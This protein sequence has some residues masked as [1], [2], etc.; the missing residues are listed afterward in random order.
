[1]GRAAPA[2]ERASSQRASIE[3]RTAEAGRADAERRLVAKQREE[4]DSLR[5]RRGAEKAALALQA[6]MAKLTKTNSDKSQHKISNAETLRL[7]TIDVQLE[8]ARHHTDDIPRLVMKAIRRVAKERSVPLL[9]VLETLV[10]QPEWKFIR[11][12]MN[13]VR[14]KEIYDHLRK[15]VYTPEHFALLRLVLTLSKRSCALMHQSFKHKRLSDGSK[16]RQR[17]ATDSKQFAPPLFSIEDIVAVEKAAEERAGV[18]LREHPDHRGADV[19][20]ARYSLDR[21][22]QSQ[23]DAQEGSRTG[24]LATA[25]TASDPDLLC[26]T[27]DGACVSGR[28][29]G[30]SFGSFV[31]STEFLNQ[32]SSN[33][34]NW[35]FYLESSKA[36][37]YLILK[38]RLAWILPDLRRIYKTRHVSPGGV[39]SPRFVDLCLTADKPFM[40]HILGLTSHNADAFGPPSCPCHGDALYN[41]T[42]DKRTHYTSPRMT[43]ESMCARAHV[44]VWEALGEDEPDQWSMHCEVCEKTWTQDGGMA[45]L[46]QDRAV[47]DRMAPAAA[48]RA[49][50]EHAGLHL[51]QCL[52]R[53][54]L[55]P[56]RHALF[57]P[58]HACHNEINALLDESVHKHLALGADSKHEQVKS[59]CATA[60]VE[61]NQLWRDANLPKFIQFG[62]VDGKELEHTLNGPAFNKAFG[63]PGL[64]QNTMNAMDAVWRLRET[65]P[66]GF[67]AAAAKSATAAAAPAGAEAPAAA[68]KAGKKQRGK[69]F[70]EAAPAPK[71]AKGKGSAGVQESEQGRRLKG[72]AC[73]AK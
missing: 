18:A 17:L 31:G 30:V 59:T 61:V 11:D 69:S 4:Q 20:G 25:G 27:G 35:L 16:S 49:M 29:S 70:T 23:L 72:E 51:G 24:G 38:A 46:S 2:A 42:F 32:S 36:E 1:M 53:P 3:M 6:E 58:M 41:F 7:R 8:L 45:Q 34:S 48:E 22:I 71:K 21:H 47:I 14:D 9:G 57:D 43:Y 55:I 28:Y 63:T 73:C 68:P 56:F 26:M 62:K 67:V 19:S 65:V 12:A 44:P 33:F 52:G 39:A 37:D 13:N 10:Q 5:R 64:L 15:H 60:Q 40:R 50:K 66:D 54:P